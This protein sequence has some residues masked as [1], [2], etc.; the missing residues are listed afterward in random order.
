MRGR[1]D[2]DLRV[3]P[4]VH[5]G[6]DVDVEMVVTSGSDTPIDFID[7]TFLGEESL[8]VLEEG[9][10]ARDAREI[11]RAH[12]RLREQGTLAEGVHRFAIKISIPADA[13][14]SYMGVRVTIRYELRL[15]VSIPWWADLRE[16]F[17]VL[18]EA[19]PP[20]R[21]K[22]QPAHESSAR[23]NDPF[24]ELALADTS[25][26][27]NDEV[28][29][30]FA[31]GNAP[32]R[33][34][35]GVE[36][37]LVAVEHANHD[38]DVRRAEQLRHMA[39]TVFATPSDGGQVPFHFRVPKEAV[40]SFRSARCDLAW[41]VQAVLRVTWA[42]VVQASLPVTIARYKVARGAGLGRPEIGAS[43]W[44]RV[45][46][47]VGER[48]G[49]SLAD[50]RLALVLAGH[51]L[52]LT[53]TRDEVQIE[54]ALDQSEDEAALVTTLRYP[55][56]GL[57]LRIAPQLVILLPDALE[58][59]L[60][61][62]RVERR[63][64]EQCKAFLTP[65]LVSGLRAFKT[66]RIDDTRAVVRKVSPGFDERALD[67]FLDKTLALVDALIAAIEGVPP[68]AAMANA[69]PA[70]R[71][72]A[73]SNGA[74]LS[75]GG[76]SLLAA[77]VDGGLFDLTT[78]FGPRGEVIGTAVQLQLDPPL[79]F[80]VDVAN[81][82]SFGAAPPGSRELA[83][84]LQASVK[85]LVIDPHFLT[86][87]LDGPTLDPADLRPRFAE[88]IVLGRRLRGERTPGPYR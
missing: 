8:A 65:E 20:Q 23:G 77:S 17:E 71:A 57:G 74:R 25:F 41:M 79:H 24:I 37:S 87:E 38:G 39:A 86:I 53:G 7:L 26:A 60:P 12:H 40:P 14:P 73:A 27:P 75:V 72:F 22:I 63:E 31:I 29:G 61:G 50:D 47:E 55:S 48:R 15:H 43:R 45:W 10:V 64:T 67:G 44:R 54:V 88:M 21:P 30:A 52:A 58:L 56:L 1:P 33:G 34:D 3:P 9:A 19:H 66:A 13:P 78:R 49:L 85:Q 16:T 28:N 83:T 51:R 46:S 80:R 18:V 76:M 42:E 36:I 82:A 11:V 81:P 2:V 5:P 59:L 4:V 35:L 70:W 68:P 6:E 32:R 62:C 84:A 69:L